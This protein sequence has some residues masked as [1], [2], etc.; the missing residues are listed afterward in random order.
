MLP[1]LHVRVEERV[2][3]R[4]SRI[5][6]G[7]RLTSSPLTLTLSTSGLGERGYL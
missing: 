6:C 7:A 4:R 2:G 3:V 5:G 1:L